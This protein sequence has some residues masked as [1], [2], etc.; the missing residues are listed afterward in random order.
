MKKII[1]LFASSVL[2]SVTNSYSQE[3]N[4]LPEIRVCEPVPTDYWLSATADEL[5]IMIEKNDVSS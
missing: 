2:F 5:M 3:K 1:L 4:D